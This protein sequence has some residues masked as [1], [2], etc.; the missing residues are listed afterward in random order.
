MFYLRIVFFQRQLQ[1][2]LSNN[3]FQDI[4]NVDNGNETYYAYI[5][6]Q[7]VFIITVGIIITI[8]K[9]EQRYEIKNLTSI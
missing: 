2:C 6:F 1:H 3:R 8:T 4:P 5:L 7:N 9:G